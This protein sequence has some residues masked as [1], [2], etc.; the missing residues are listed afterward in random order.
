M[1]VSTALILSLGGLFSLH[2]YLIF[3]NKS[4]LEMTDLIDNPFNRVRKVIKSQAEKRER[5]PIRLF[6]GTQRAATM[7]QKNRANPYHNNKQMKE[8]TNRLLNAADAMGGDMTYWPLPWAP[9]GD[10]PACD[11]FNWHIRTIH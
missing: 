10:H 2:S 6:T 7:A 11:G 9:E 1:M 8:V 3:S 4:T 5:T